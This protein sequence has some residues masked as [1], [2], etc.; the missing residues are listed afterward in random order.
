MSG[1]ARYAP[2]T[3]FSFVDETQLDEYVER[4]KRIET[5]KEYLNLENA[6]GGASRSGMR[7]LKM[8]QY[9]SMTIRKSSEKAS[10]SKDGVYNDD[11]LALQL[12]KK[13]GVAP[14]MEMWSERMRYWLSN[15][16]LKPLTKWFDEVVEHMGKDALYQ[17]QLSQVQSGVQKLQTQQANMFSVKPSLMGGAS[18]AA[19]TQ[20]QQQQQQNLAQRMKL[21]RLFGDFGTSREYVVE[22]IRTLAQ[23]VI[24][25]SYNWCAGG[26]WKDKEWTTDLPTDAQIVCHLFC[27][28]LDELV[29]ATDAAHAHDAF[30]SRYLVGKDETA[31]KPAFA[32][33]QRSV[34]PPHYNL[35]VNRQEWNVLKGRN[36]LFDALC[37]FLYVVQRDYQ[38]KLDQRYLGGNVGLLD[39]L[40][41]AEDD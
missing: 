15:C 13:E 33:I 2:S 11:G 25:Q 23:G 32:I 29:V 41:T 38:G 39:V 30:R 3:D 5:T 8:P 16:V 1:N 36:N 20:S 34:N 18:A 31:K 7:A 4:Q 6:S 12:Y 19:S 9:Q 28:H 27:T 17:A 37:L 14:Y 22:R 21:E 26:K 24:L 40:S 35:I 10:S